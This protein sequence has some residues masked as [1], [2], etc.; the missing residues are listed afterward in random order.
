MSGRIRRLLRTVP[1]GRIDLGELPGPAAASCSALSPARW[2]AKRML[3]ERLRGVDPA[4]C[5]VLGPGRLVDATTMP[6]DCATYPLSEADGLIGSAALSWIVVGDALA[7]QSD[8]PAVLGRLAELYAGGKPLRFL[9]LLPG[10]ATLPDN[11][12]PSP[13]RWLFSR[14]SAARMAAEAFGGIAADVHT[15]GNALVASSEG[16]GLAAQ[17]LWTDE[18]EFVDPQYPVVVTLTTR[19]ASA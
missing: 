3:A 15:A 10:T 6:L 7:A 14:A 13:R 8:P 1:K 11:V 16:L 18:L 19:P 17:D 9:G 5:W 4:H 2:L 12:P